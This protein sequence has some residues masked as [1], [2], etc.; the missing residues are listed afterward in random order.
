VPKSHR[1]VVFAKMRKRRRRR[2]MKR[3][4]MMN[5]RPNWT[6]CTRLA[7]FGKYLKLKRGG[8]YYNYKERALNAIFPKKGTLT[9]PFVHC[10]HPRS[11]LHFFC[12]FS[13]SNPCE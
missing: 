12:P 10:L 9:D 7:P 5:R 4:K 8:N 11:H 2:R 3:K 1:N 6:K 13:S